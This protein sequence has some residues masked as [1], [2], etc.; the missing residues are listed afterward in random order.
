MIALLGPAVC[1]RWLFFCGGMNERMLACRTYA[2]HRDINAFQ[3]SENNNKISPKFT[4]SKCLF[5]D[6]N[7]ILCRRA[8]A[9]SKDI[10]NEYWASAWQRNR[11]RCMDT[12]VHI[13]CPP[14]RPM[15]TLKEHEKCTSMIL[16]NSRETK[17]FPIVDDIPRL[18]WLID[19]TSARG[20]PS[21]I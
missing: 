14:A 12:E 7:D 10:V 16:S 20:R 13:E 11:M 17:R 19:A 8:V 2:L 9:T 5:T 1:Y 6:S 15:R 4:M 21:H 18:T 3:W